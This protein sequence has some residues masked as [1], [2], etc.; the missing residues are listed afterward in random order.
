M[1]R[2]RVYLVGLSDGLSVHGS[3]DTTIGPFR[4]RR[5]NL[6][7]GDVQLI[8]T[9]AAKRSRVSNADFC[10]PQT[11]ASAMRL[12][13]LAEARRPEVVECA[14]CATS[15]S[16]NPQIANRGFEVSHRRVVMRPASEKRQ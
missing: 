15:N 11:G 12:K 3:K 14:I 9:G 1:S 8:L 2:G 10:C 5:Q 6:T 16:L 7:C 4:Q 13:D